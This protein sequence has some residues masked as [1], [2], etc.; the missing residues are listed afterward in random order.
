MSG[1]CNLRPPGAPCM[2]YRIAAGAVT[3]GNRGSAPLVTGPYAR[4]ARTGSQQGLS[5]GA[6]Y[7]CAPCADP[8]LQGPRSSRRFRIPDVRLREL[9]GYPGSADRPLRLD[10][11]PEDPDPARRPAPGLRSP[12]A[13]GSEVFARQYLSSRQQPLPVLWQEVFVIGALA[14]SRHPDL[15]RRKVVVGER[16]LRMPS[17]QCAKGKQAP[18]RVRDASDPSSPAAEVASAASPSGTELPGHLEELSRR[19]VLERGTEVLGLHGQVLNLF[20][21]VDELIH[22]NAVLLFIQR[23]IAAADRH[24]FVMRSALDDA[25]IFQDQDLIRFPNRREA[26]CNDECRPVPHQRVEAVL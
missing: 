17:L 25:S 23:A 3:L 10:A 21:L 8:V 14:R 18:E 13:S 5:G 11:A 1:F 19:G 2:M 12:S 15:A 20:A 9:D 26:V 22:D 7:L 24:Q 6:D 4:W 16:G